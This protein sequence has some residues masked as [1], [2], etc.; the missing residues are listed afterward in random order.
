MC[1][2]CFQLI[3]NAHKMVTVYV[4]ELSDNKY[5]V[6][7]TNNFDP[8]IKDHITNNG[9]AWTTKYKPLTLVEKYDNCDDFDEDKYVKIYMMR[10]GIDNVRGGSYSQIVLEPNVIEMLNKE[11]CSATDKCFTC[12]LSS[13]F[14]KECRGKEIEE[15]YYE[16]NNSEDIDMGVDAEYNHCSQ[17]YNVEKHVTYY[18]TLHKLPPYYIKHQKDALHS[19][20]SC[21]TALNIRLIG[22]ETRHIDA[23]DTKYD[24]RYKSN[25]DDN[26]KNTLNRIRYNRKIIKCLQ[27]ILN[28]LEL[29]KHT[30]T[31]YDKYEYI[32]KYMICGITNDTNN[33]NN[34]Q[35]F[36]FESM[37]NRRLMGQMN[38]MTLI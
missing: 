1:I 2:R 8:R 10:Y 38:N 34:N 7:K 29:T 30:D 19:I 5:Y 36:D 25:T 28:L 14:T 12:G 15:M 37:I 9:S 20:I 4:L 31:L 26:L 18:I 6:G 21:M 22:H 35:K 24:I 3:D 11:L 23:L 16:L 32:F 17:V 27:K 33:T 13:H